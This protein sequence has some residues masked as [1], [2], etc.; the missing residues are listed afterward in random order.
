MV[1]TRVKRRVC[2]LM[3][4]SMVSN[5][6]R[7]WDAHT[8]GGRIEECA[9][10]ALRAASSFGRVRGALRNLI[11]RAV[12][13]AHRHLSVR[14]VVRARVRAY[15]CVVCARSS[16]R[17]LLPPM[18]RVGRTRAGR[19]DRSKFT[20]AYIDDCALGVACRA[21]SSCG[22]YGETFLWPPEFWVPPHRRGGPS[23]ARHDDTNVATDIADVRAARMHRT[24]TRTRTRTNDERRGCARGRIASIARRRLL[25]RLYGRADMRQRWPTAQTGA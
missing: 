20:H 19:A 24:R 2:N 1:C 13:R 12:S 22:M 14:A 7:A 9:L 21:S 5:E 23:R 17:A 6:C 10:L 25:A 8:A 4:A 16:V 18:P 15:L 11:S 3:R